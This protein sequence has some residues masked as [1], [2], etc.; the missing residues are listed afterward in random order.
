MDEWG[1]SRLNGK[2]SLF[3]SLY[4]YLAYVFCKTLQFNETALCHVQTL[5]KIFTSCYTE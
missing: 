2:I 1:T 5:S 4:I 3:L